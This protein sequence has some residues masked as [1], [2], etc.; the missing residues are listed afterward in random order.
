MG[1]IA[2]KRWSESAR[3]H[4]GMKLKSRKK[5]N[6]RDTETKIAG[7]EPCLDSYHIK[8]K[9]TLILFMHWHTRS[10]ASFI[11]LQAQTFAH[12]H[13]YNNLPHVYLSLEDGTY[14]V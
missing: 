5:S 1:C 2:R 13:H 14:Q 6:E 9:Y 10:S 12:M 7:G 3:E 11:F 8:K 4:K